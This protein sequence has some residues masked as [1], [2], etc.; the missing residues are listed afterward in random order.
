MNCRMSQNSSDDQRRQIEQAR[1][2][3]ES[4]LADHQFVVV[5]Q[6]L[7]LRHHNDQRQHQQSA[8]PQRIAPNQS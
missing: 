1:H 4:R 5:V 3:V 6:T 7:D 2:L 8:Q